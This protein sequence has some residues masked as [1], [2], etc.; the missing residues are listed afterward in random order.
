MNEYKRWAATEEDLKDLTPVKARGMIVNCFFD[1]QKETFARAKERLRMPASDEDLKKSVTAAVRLAFAE[2]GGA[3]ENPTK[4][5]LM[6]A[7]SSLAEKAASWKTPEDI[8]NHH[9]EQI[10]L[11]L[12]IL[13]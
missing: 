4:E 7:V 9:K 11:V 8:I 2:C 12:G 3:F 6:L 5:C 10:M 1:A 13:K